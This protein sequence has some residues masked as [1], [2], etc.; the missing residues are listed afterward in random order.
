MVAE[1]VL[2]ANAFVSNAFKTFP[3]FMINRGAVRAI[4]CPPSAV[5]VLS[6]RH[7]ESMNNDELNSTGFDTSCN[8]SSCRCL[9][10]TVRVGWLVARE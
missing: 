1:C 8:S 4:N 9:C 2:N 7:A 3:D 10:F 5:A 6:K